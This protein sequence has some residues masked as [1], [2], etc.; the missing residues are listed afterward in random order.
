LTVRIESLSKVYGLTWALRGID[1]EFA[2]GACVALLGPNGAGK[3]TLLKLLAALIYPT[4]GKI[5]LAGQKLPYG[6]SPLRSRIGFLSADAHLYDNL[7]ASENLRFFVSLYQGDTTQECIGRALDSVGLAPW[8][9]EYVS[10]LSHG[11]R[12]RLAIAKWSILRPRLLLIDEPYG[13]LD[14]SG[15]VVL[16]TFIKSICAAGG[17]V[18][19]ATHN[20][21][22]AIALCSRAI[23]LHQG[24]ILFDEARQEP[25][26]SFYRAFADFFPREDPGS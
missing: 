13:S 5:E 22:R 24:R 26:D 19:V 23:I 2:K 15:V 18:V 20:V 21:T 7:T 10:A 3:T 16:E 14:G 4:D 1:L 25:W 6:N 9:S 11:M 17:T 12:C 8:A